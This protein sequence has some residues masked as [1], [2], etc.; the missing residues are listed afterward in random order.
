MKE[1]AL[2]T[3]E[4]HII[5]F[6]KLSQGFKKIQ[7]SPNLWVYPT[8]SLSRWFYPLSGYLLVK[9]LFFRPLFGPGGVKQERPI[10]LVTAQDPFESGLTAY[11]SAKKLRVPL[12]LQI[13]T[14]F[15]SPAFTLGSRLN[16]IRMWIAKFLLSRHP[17]L[18]VVSEK[19]KKSILEK[20]SFPLGD[21][22]KVNV[23]PVFVDVSK[24]KNAPETR[25]LREK[26]TGND[27]LLLAVSRLEP[28]KNISLAIR[29]V[30]EAAKRKPDSVV[31]LVIAGTGSEEKALRKMAQKCHISD[32]VFFEG[33][34]ADLSP[35]YR[36]V[37][38]LLVTSLY[39]GYGMV[40]AE[41]V[42]SGCPVLTLNVGAARD[43][44]GQ[45][46][47]IVCDEGDENCLLQNI[48]RLADSSDARE[49]FLVAA[50]SEAQKF[51][52]K[53]K[54]QYLSELKLLWEQTA[55]NDSFV[56]RL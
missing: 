30:A 34:I 8:R 5:V 43:I 19:I 40:F 42:A 52:P 48:L 56:G 29:L 23:F 27:L 18:R 53:T 37:D 13:H 6:T 16:T 21:T 35:Y 44:V 26:Y 2:L 25:F 46:N 17:Y 39:E 14:D 33:Y 4:L 1:Y 55:E 9:Y 32:R 49:R 31:A 41:A 50:R 3:E 38:A 10:T 15:L 51:E 24:Y 54:E 11:L 20:I 12:E 47:G 45:W 28:E 36:S 7:I 22:P